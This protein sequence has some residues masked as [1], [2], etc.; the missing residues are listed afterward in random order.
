MKSLYQ[1]PKF[2]EYWDK[3]AGNSGEIYKRMVLDPLMFKLIGSLSNKVI[4]ELGCGN[5]YL[6]PMFVSQKPKRIILLDISK[7]NLQFAKEKCDDSRIIFLEQDATKKWKVN[8][9]SID[10]LYSNMMLNEVKDIKTPIKEAF[11]VLKNN[12]ILIFSVT[13]PAWDLYVFA[14]EVAG[15][16][17]N[18]IRGLG[19][20]FRRGFAKY[21]MGK[22]SKTNPS[23]AEKYKQE[24]EVEHYQRPL[25][26]YFNELTNIGFSVKKILEPELTNELLQENPRFSEYMN[27]PVGLVFFCRKELVA[28]KQNL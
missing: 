22:D 27:H 11:R 28:K 14:Q 1:N 8:S 6:G 16:K 18:K 21:I 26:D 5:G 13:H 12:G 15:V 7:Y 9:N 24:F 23:L 3:R 25:S 19:N 20:Y 10:I 4:L 2:A 17:S